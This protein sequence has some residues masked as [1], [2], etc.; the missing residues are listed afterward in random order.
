MDCCC[1][2]GRD[3]TAPRRIAVSASQVLLEEKYRR[4]QSFGTYLE[5]HP[6]HSGTPLGKELLRA[7]SI[8]RMAIHNILQEMRSA[9]Q[10]G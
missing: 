9:N 4:A 10:S 2:M 5:Q 6:T 3:E 7:T 1:E 8:Y